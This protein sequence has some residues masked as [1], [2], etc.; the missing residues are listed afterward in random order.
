VARPL[1]EEY[2]ARRD[3]YD[4]VSLFTIG[5]GGAPLSPTLKT[6]MADLIPNVFIADGYGTSETGAQATNLGG[7]R[8]SPMDPNT[9]VLDETTLEPVAP[10]SG[11]VGRVARRGHIPFAYH[12][13]PEKT[14]ATF[15][16]HAGDRWV[17]TGDMATVLED[18]SIELLGRGSQCINTGGEKVFPEEV[19]SALKAHPAVYDAVV[20]GVADDRWGQ[21]VTAVVQPRAGASVD[22]D[23][24]QAH[25]RTLLAAYKVPR[26]LV[27]VDEV[28]RSPVGKPDY[29]WAQATAD[30]AG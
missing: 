29:R 5:S 3:E 25:C 17:L 22:L 20:V 26:D 16:E 23:D 1:I 11:G 24:L 14:A 28:V 10:G 12:N 30:A 9:T 6:A 4:I 7:G 13:D 18:G 8:W 21:R 27:V 2:M 15:V 19:E